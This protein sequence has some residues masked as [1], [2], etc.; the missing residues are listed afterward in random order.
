MLVY[1]QQQQLDQFSA[2]VWYATFCT[3]PGISGVQLAK[4]HVTL[5]TNLLGSSR[6]G[7]RDVYS[8]SHYFLLS[9][10][11]PFFGG[12][13][14]VRRDSAPPTSIRQVQE[15]ASI[16]YSP[17]DKGVASSLPRPHRIS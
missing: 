14:L 8:Y 4:L 17:D 6:I 15:G 2:H 11:P 10:S 9:S 1:T 3:S 16:S 7:P 13:T 5:M 12:H